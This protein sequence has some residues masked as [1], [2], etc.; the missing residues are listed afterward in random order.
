MIVVAHKIV[1]VTGE[2]VVADGKMVMVVT[3]ELALHIR[4]FVQKDAHPCPQAQRLVA[5]SAQVR[6]DDLWVT[7]Q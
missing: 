4:I 5:M 2:M 7:V 3:G 6:C 1:V